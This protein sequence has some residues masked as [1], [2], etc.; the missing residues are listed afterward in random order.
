MDQRLLRRLERE[1]LLEEQQPSIRKRAPVKRMPKKTPPPPPPSSVQNMYEI[2]PKEL[3]VESP[4]PNFHLHQFKLPFR[5]CC[6]APSGS[7]KTNWLVNLLALFSRDPGTFHHITICTR[8]KDEPL[9]KWLEGLNDRIKIVEGLENA[10]I[11]DKMDKDFNNLVIFDDLVL[12]K[13]QTRV[14]NY[15]IRARK[16]NCSVC[17]LSQSYFAIPKIVRSNCT[18]LVLLKLSG[19]RELNLILSEG[20]LGIDK[21]ELLRIYK[22]ATAEKFSPL[23]IDYEAEQD[24]RYRKGFTE[25]VPVQE[26]QTA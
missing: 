4:N 3:L 2:M 19:A 20:G 18:Y 7:G 1:I 25:Y 6:V 22:E 10:P 26:K 12:E 11:L 17:Y 5:L 21:N 9:Y 24:K 8:N 16:L 23:I 15:Y 14:A 13:N